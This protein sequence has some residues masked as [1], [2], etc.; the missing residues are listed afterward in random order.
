M[1][2]RNIPSNVSSAIVQHIYDTPHMQCICQADRVETRLND[3][4]HFSIHY[5]NKWPNFICYTFLIKR[6]GGYEESRSTLRKRNDNSPSKSFQNSQIANGAQTI[7]SPPSKLLLDKK[8]QY[9]SLTTSTAPVSKL[10]IPRSVVSE[11]SVFPLPFQQ[12]SNQQ[13]Q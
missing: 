2:N 9:T 11:A 10:T 1:S 5:T 4:K 8:Q 13:D 6:K 12:Q 3:G 7:E